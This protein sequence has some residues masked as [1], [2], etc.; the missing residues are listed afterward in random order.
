VIAT[1]RLGVERRVYYIE[2]RHW[3]SGKSPGPQHVGDF[4]EI[5]LRDH[6]HGGL[7]LSSS[8]FAPGGVGSRAAVVE[9]S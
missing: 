9:F 7:F 5:N 2:I 6:T 3:R 1:V 4:V 8:G